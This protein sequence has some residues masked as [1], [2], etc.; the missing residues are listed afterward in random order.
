MTLSARVFLP[1]ALLLSAPALLNQTL[2]AQTTLA[3]APTMLRASL[4]E[5]PS[6]ASSSSSVAGEPTAETGGEPGAAPEPVWA[7]EPAVPGARA[8]RGV[9]GG[10]AQPS[11]YGPGMR[12]FRSF[13]AGVVLGDQGIGFEVATPLAARLNLRAGAQFFGLNATF[14]NDG[15]QGNGQLSL[16]NV[17][18]AV[19]IYPF[20]RSSFHISPGVTLH[21]DTH[22]YATL[23]AP[24]G[25]SFSLGDAD[26][27]SDPTNPIHGYT[28]FIFGNTV[29]PRLTAGFGNMIPRTGAHFSFPVEIGFQYISAPAVQLQL[30]GNGC[31]ADGCGDINSNGGDQNIQDEIKLLESDLAPLRFYPV[32][33][34]GVSYRFG[35][36]GSR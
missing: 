23:L 2:L 16:E 34:V 15:L 8:A 21:N 20:R 18:A 27:T 9:R 7:P 14:T 13:A 30:A 33:T 29:A 32:V 1:A 5:A 12:P 11:E 25:T 10:G 36:S 19:D 28:R 17:F 6:S 22:L 26:Y 35:R 24:G 31:D 4:V 3:Q